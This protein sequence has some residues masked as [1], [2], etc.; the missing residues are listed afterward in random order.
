MIFFDIDDTLIDF[1]TAE[2]LGV[3]DF[4]TL[5]KNCF[6][7]DEETFHK[8][9]SNISEK[10]YN[11]FLKGELSFKQQRVERLKEI[12]A[13][14]DIKLSDEEAL[15]RF[16]IYSKAFEDN[17]R[18]FDDV[19]ICL[20]SLSEY[21]LGIISNGDLNQQNGKLERM[22]IRRYFKYVITSGEFGVSKPDVKIFEIACQKANKPV[23]EC[24]YVGDRYK[25]DIVPC[26]EISMNCIWLNRKHEKMI[27]NNVIIVSNLIETIPILTKQ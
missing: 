16:L 12:F 25:T 5:F 19:I 17:W 9:W 18:L 27:D 26:M 21:E 7:C 2:Y 10:N 1:K 24:W 8:Y 23:T 3:K 14:S 11:R 15:D 4:Y 20:Q 13:L 6:E 22:N